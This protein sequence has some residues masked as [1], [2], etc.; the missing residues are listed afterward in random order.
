MTTYL[1]CCQKER[2]QIVLQWRNSLK[3]YEGESSQLPLQLEFL[4]QWKKL[5]RAP[6]AYNT[7]TFRNQI[8]WM[9]TL[10]AS[11]SDYDGSDNTAHHDDACV[12]FIKDDNNY[13]FIKSLL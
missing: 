6:D 13:S 9:G 12:C 2:V 1:R 8:V 11:T 3:E 5:V 7:K 4:F 10:K